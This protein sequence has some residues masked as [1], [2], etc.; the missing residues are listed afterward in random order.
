MQQP[1]YNTR[2]RVAMNVLKAGLATTA[3]AL[4]GAPGASAAKPTHKLSAAQRIEKRIKHHQPVRFDT[5]FDYAWALPGSKHLADKLTTLPVIG[6]DSGKN[7]FFKLVQRGGTLASVQA[8]ELPVGGNRIESMHDA[9]YNCGTEPNHSAPVGLDAQGKPVV[10]L[11]YSDG[12]TYDDVP[13]GHTSPFETDG[14]IIGPPPVQPGACQ[15][16]TPPPGPPVPPVVTDPENAF[17]PV[18]TDPA[19]AFQPAVYEV[20]N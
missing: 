10:T 7:R 11:T 9:Y 5:N 13:V 2:G 16:D 6:K 1:T 19:N 4:F 12:K 18:V 17:H 14:P 8:V 20:G 15:S 3:I